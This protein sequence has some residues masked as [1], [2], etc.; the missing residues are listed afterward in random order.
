MASILEECDTD[1]LHCM[2]CS[3]E[4]LHQVGNQRACAVILAL[5]QDRTDCVGSAT[6]AGSLSNI[7]RW[8]LLTLAAV[9][10]CTQCVMD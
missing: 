10:F 5:G 2:R 1:I 4:I 9:R 8:I 3:A 7:R 6:D